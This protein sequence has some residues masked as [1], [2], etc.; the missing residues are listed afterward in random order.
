M[1]SPD[2]HSLGYIS[3]AQGLNGSVRLNTEYPEI[4]PGIKGKTVYLT[5]G[6]K[7]F[8]FLL[9]A[10]RPHDKESVVLSLKS[11]ESREM[12]ESLIGFTL[13]VGK[14]ELPVGTGKQFF[15]HELEGMKVEDAKLGLI[16]TIEAVY[17]SPAHPV[18]A[19]NYQ[20]T[21]ILLPLAQHFLL[22]IDRPN[23]VLRMDLPDG[24]LE[25]YLNPSAEE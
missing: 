1:A 3:R 18:A 2:L 24:L 13:S 9:Q 25:V 11:C 21:E 10:I 4:L 20:G 22:S 16:G 12:A 6:D 7:Q 14:T 23:K 17:P 15:V 5:K 8:S 19:L